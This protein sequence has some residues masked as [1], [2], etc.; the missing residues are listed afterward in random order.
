[1]G[2]D[3]AAD[4]FLTSGGTLAN[5]TALLTARSKISGKNIWNDGYKNQKYAIMVSSQAH[6]CVDR[7]ARIMGLG[8]EGIIVIP[9]NERFQMDISF[10]EECYT[11]ATKKGIQIF[12]VVGSACSTSTG[13][14]D[15]L[16][17]IGAFA[18]SKKIWFHVDG[19]HGGA[20]VFSEKYR[21]LLKGIDQ[22][23]SVIVDCHKMMMTP[24]LATA[25]VYKQ[26]E[27]SYATFAQHAQYLFD[28]EE[29][30]WHN[31]A[32]RTFECTKFMMSVKFATILLMHGKKGIG[33]FVTK[34]YDLG[35]EF[36]GLIRNRNSFELAHNPESNIVCYR[37]KGQDLSTEEREL[38]NYKV[39]QYL[40]EDGK[41]YVVQT[42][43]NNQVYLRSTIMNPF[44]TA[45]EFNELLDYME[46][47]AFSG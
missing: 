3:D 44:T 21:P 14:Y 11:E 10:L 24:A 43:L 17:A 45:N 8:N 13:S 7:A 25:L 38:L 16:E 4:G 41:F 27:N 39:R 37:L 15:D 30:E 28:R 9:V 31:L 2:F 18:S 33:G 47:I 35:Q 36:A 19:A 29:Q 22:A 12:A 32:K 34:L 23:D 42:K 5:M 46:K 20:A 26:G 1:M 40:L 6:Y